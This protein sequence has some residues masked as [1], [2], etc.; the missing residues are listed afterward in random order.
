MPAGFLP[1]QIARDFVLGVHRDALGVERVR[2]YAIE[3][4]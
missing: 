4:P 1:L 3:R 2:E